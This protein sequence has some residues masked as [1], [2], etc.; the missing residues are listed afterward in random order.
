M[1]ATALAVI[2]TIKSAV[3]VAVSR[4]VR[5][6]APIPYMLVELYRLA[7]A[8]QEV[9]YFGAHGEGLEMHVIG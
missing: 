3:L 8:C 2:A 7:G 1:D 4:C 9:L 5:F 6:A